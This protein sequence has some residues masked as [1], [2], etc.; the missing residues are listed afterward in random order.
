MSRNI[1]QLGTPIPIHKHFDQMHVGMHPNIKHSTEHTQLS[2]PRSAILTIDLLN[3]LN[4]S[5][6]FSVFFSMAPCP[7][8]P[9]S[10]KL[11]RRVDH[12]TMYNVDN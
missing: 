11:V 6:K 2:A 3:M 5:Q 10:E 4:T 8:Y 1:R 12:N 9:L 7:N